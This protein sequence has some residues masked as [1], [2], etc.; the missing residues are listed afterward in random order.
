MVQIRSPAIADLAAVHLAIPLEVEGNCLV[1]MKKKFSAKHHLK[2]TDATDLLK[3][4]FGA[5]SHGHNS[6]GGGVRYL[7]ILRHGAP[8]V[9]P[10]GGYPT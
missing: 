2:A 5:E 8:A 7:P 1:I 6:E 10:L 9:N 3:D 4:G